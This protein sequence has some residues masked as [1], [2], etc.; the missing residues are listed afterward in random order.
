MNEQHLVAEIAGV[1]HAGR[2]LDRALAVVTAGAMLF[3]AVG[4]TLFA[5]HHGVPLYAAWALD[6]L[7][8]SA[9]YAV[10]QAAA[11]LGRHGVQPG[12][13]PTVLQLFAGTAT[14]TMNVWAPVA[15]RDPAGIVVHAVP[16]LLM[17][18]LGLAAPRLRKRFAE[19]VARLRGELEQLRAA[20][21]A[22]RQADIER[23][24]AAR[25]AAAEA[26]RAQRERERAERDRERETE[27]E[28]E[29]R[30]RPKVVTAGKTAEQIIREAWEADRKAGEPIVA[31]RY[32]RLAGTN[33]YARGLIRKW[34]AELDGEPAE[35]VA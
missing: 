15:G 29:T 10:L 20:E 5:N 22:R 12:V 11:I 13:W 27:T 24:T 26:F 18:V 6:P 3:A 2:T 23:E 25:E 28:T 4:V 32:D 33:N 16:P 31:A 35:A 7:V 9:L 21:S 14:L 34:T 17:I 8:A 1:Q 19:V 30:P